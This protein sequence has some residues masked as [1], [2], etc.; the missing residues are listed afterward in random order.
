M[1]VGSDQRGEG[2]SAGVDTVPTTPSERASSGGGAPLREALDQ[3]RRTHAGG[4]GPGGTTRPGPRSTRGAGAPPPFDHRAAPAGPGGDAVLGARPPRAARHGQDQLKTRPA[5][6]DSGRTSTETSVPTAWSGAAAVSEPLFATEAPEAAYA[7]PPDEEARPRPSIVELT[8]SGYDAVLAAE[9]GEAYRSASA[10]RAPADAATVPPP[11]APA[12]AAATWDAV[13]AATTP[14][15]APTTP[16]LEATAAPGAVATNG[17]RPDLIAGVAGKVAFRRTRATANLSADEVLDILL[18]VP[19]DRVATSPAA[20]VAPPEPT[21]PASRVD[22]AP[23]QSSL[24]PPLAVPPVVEQAHPTPPPAAPV[25]PPPPPTPTLSP[26]PPPPAPPVGSFPDATPVGAATPST[27]AETAPDMA[28]HAF[29]SSV[30]EG[31]ATWAP[32]ERAAPDLTASPPGVVDAATPD[33]TGASAVAVPSF[34][35]AGTLEPE[36]AGPVAASSEP[37]FAAEPDRPGDELGDEVDEDR[38]MSSA[39][40]MAT[41]ILSAAPDVPGVAP[42]EE[43]NESQIIS[44]DLTLIARGRQKRFRLR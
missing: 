4:T 42:V 6:A 34:E 43:A 27:G 14:P 41:E 21:A 29:E 38:P 24:A 15:P 20:D 9:F 10:T 2:R 39:A 18:G 1:T 13:V 37:L 35:P 36:P 3:I 22:L 31:P 33:P 5:P 25:T 11:P 30:A 8:P 7:T 32:D 26:P 16:A 28:T 19:A 12:G 17:H 44:K 23:P 40:S